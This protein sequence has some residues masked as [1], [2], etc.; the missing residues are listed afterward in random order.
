MKKAKI[1]SLLI[2][3]V[4]IFTLFPMS[5]RVTADEEN[6]TQQIAIDTVVGIGLMQLDADGMFLPDVKVTR[7]DF[8]SIIASM[9][10]T[11]DQA[12]AEWKEM[13]FKDYNEAFE[14]TDSFSGAVEIFSD[15]DS[16][17]EHYNAV[18]TVNELGIMTGYTDGSFRPENQITYEQ[19]IKV[20]VTLLGYKVKAELYGGFPSGYLRMA[21][22]LKLLN[23]LSATTGLITRGD[24]AILIYNTLDVRMF[25]VVSVGKNVKYSSENSD[26]FLQSFLGM[27]KITGR[28]TDNGFSNFMGVRTNSHSFMTIG[29][30][31]VRTNDDKAYARGYLGRTV[32]AYVEDNNGDYTL[33]YA[34]LDGLDKVVTIDINDFMSYDRGKITFTAGKNTKTVSFDETA[35][36]IYNGSGI[37]RF[38]ENIFDFS[39]GTI[40]VVTPKGAGEAD[41]I[42]VEAYESYYVDYVDYD[43]KAVYSKK[44]VNN[45]YASDTINLDRDEHY[46]LSIKKADGTPADITGITSDCVISVSEGVNSL[47]VIISTE[48]ATS[49][50]VNEIKTASDA[51]YISNGTASYPLSE[52]FINLNI[53]GNE[54]QSYGIIVGDSYTVYFDIFGE[55]VYLK[56]ESAGTGKY[57]TALVINTIQTKGVDPSTIIRVIKSDGIVSNYEIASKVSVSGDSDITRSVNDQKQ[58]TENDF[59]ALIKDYHGIIRFTLNAK[60]E[61]NYLEFPIKQVAF[62]NPD[63][64]LA[65]IYLPDTDGVTENEL[66]NLY[67]KNGAIEGWLYKPNQGFVGQVLVNTT[68]KVF[69]SPK[70]PSA[71]EIEY[72]ELM[73]AY[74]SQ[75]IDEQFYEVSAPS[76]NFGDATRAIIKGY[77]TVAD[78]RCAQFLVN[79]R[80]IAKSK[81]THENR[82]FYV[83]NRKYQAL[84]E[85]GMACTVISCFQGTTEKNI[86]LSDECDGVESMLNPGVVLEDFELEK[87][88]IFRYATDAYGKVVTLQI[89]VDENASNPASLYANYVGNLYATEGRWGSA[90][91]GQTNPYTVITDSVG[92]NSFDTVKGHWWAENNQGS[93]RNALYWVVYTRNGNEVCL[94]TQPL[95][96]K[97]ETYQLDE[98][99]EVFVTDSYV[100]SNVNAVT[101]TANGV[102]VKS[103][104]VSQLKSY[105]FTANNCDRVFIS[106]RVGVSSSTIVYTNYSSDIEN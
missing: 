12:L 39:N 52:R 35:C 19:A 10:L 92:N 45:T 84:D 26:T 1:L 6:T 47:T 49:F 67:F 17:S 23:G 16:T 75:V 33:V 103:I 38:D 58:K 66:R 25:D 81:L 89:I 27:R 65:E 41:I 70:K 7:G 57:I 13:F 56:S 59:Y 87:G 102:S 43:N 9:F 101:I 69:V 83:F 37:D 99:G 96:S 77:T 20:I 100:M 95:G 3:L 91:P 80:S 71:N 11:S 48:K 74:N 44:N 4:M 2:G 61:L 64:R 34:A 36:M 32:N 5:I 78:S 15:V 79:C 31:S 90:T 82:T 93:M 53:A 88:D 50:V 29:G 73:D 98:N 106:S 28:V 51:T 30:I 105:E 104:P 18:K 54:D 42:I 55:A 46:F 21:N 68:T 85:N 63:N 76:S 14:V 86:F 40:S 60:E 22:E 8:A 97:G 72:E 62:G 24:A 94:T